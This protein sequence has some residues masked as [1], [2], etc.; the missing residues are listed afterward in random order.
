MATLGGWF[1]DQTV[2][3]QPRSTRRAFAEERQSSAWPKSTEGSAAPLLLSA[4][5]SDSHAAFLQL[6]SASEDHS[7]GSGGDKGVKHMHEDAEDHC[8]PWVV[9]PHRGLALFLPAN[10]THLSQLPLNT[11]LHDT[12]VPRCA[13]NP[14]SVP[15]ISPKIPISLWSD[16]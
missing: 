13:P 9:V 1:R 14:T 7:L 11:W 6:Q 10:L 15:G 5:F 8:A 4:S 12:A 16:L 2:T 3:R